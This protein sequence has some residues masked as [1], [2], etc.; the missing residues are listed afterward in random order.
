VTFY[1]K[2]FHSQTMPSKRSLL[3]QKLAQR[4]ASDTPDVPGD[5]AAVIRAAA[6]GPPDPRPV[7]GVL[8]EGLAYII[9]TALPWERQHDYAV[10]AVRMVMQ[11]TNLRG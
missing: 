7:I 10:A 9:R 3:L 8:V 2:S 11:R 6:E 5:L 4:A 1:L